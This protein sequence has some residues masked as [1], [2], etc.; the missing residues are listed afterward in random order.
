MHDSETFCPHLLKDLSANPGLLAEAA[1]FATIAGQH[2]LITSQTL[3]TVANSVTKVVNTNL[4]FEG[5]HQYIRDIQVFKQLNVDAY[6]KSGVFSSAEHAKSYLANASEGQLGALNR[7]LSGTGQE[8]DW[9]RLKQGQLGSVLEKS[10]L[11]GNHAPGVDGET[12]NRFTGEQIS[13]T[14]V[15]AGQSMNSMS[16][17]IDKVLNALEKGTLEPNDIV[18]GIEGTED[19]LKTKLETAIDS[20]TKNGDMEYLE[21]LKAAREHLKVEEFNTTDSVTESVDRL[22]EKIDAGQA[23]ST[24]TLQEVSRKAVNGAVI[25]AAIG[26]T[27][28]A[29]SNYMKYKNGELT[30]QEAMTLVGR[31][32]TKGALVGGAMGAVTIFLPAGALGFVGGLAIGI[33]LNQTLTNVLDEVFGKGAF[34]AILDSAGFVNG[35]AHSLESSL[36]KIKADERTIQTNRRQ[37]NRKRKQIQNNFNEFDALMKGR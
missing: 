26:L 16:G 12:I 31:D 21:R 3:D 24:V 29:V 18:A 1:N 33:Y 15:K 30:E 10:N 22:T 7:N 32:T 11:I 35:M 36:Q 17:N 5:T 8:V 34:G 9:L 14:S 28:S 6:S 4:S 23:H 25:G 2:H 37:I 13:R 27:V 20:A 19:I